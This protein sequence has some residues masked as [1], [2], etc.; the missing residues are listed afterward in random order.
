[1]ERTRSDIRPLDG[2]L[3]TAPKVL[4]AIRMNATLNVADRMVHESVNVVRRDLPIRTQRVGVENRSE[5]DVRVN[6]GEQH[7]RLVVR[8]YESAD[9]AFL[10][11]VATLDHAEYRRFACGRSMRE[12]AESALRKVVRP[13]FAADERFVCFDLALERRT[14]VRFRGFA[15]PM[16]HEPRRFLRHAERAGEFV[17]GRTVF[18]VRQEPDSGKPL[19]KRDRAVVEDGSPP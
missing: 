2:A 7:G 9:A 4:N 8:N 17:R 1:M 14:V 19:G 13:H 5:F 15:N 11:F 16:E 12:F 10:G 6:L 3:Q 18:R